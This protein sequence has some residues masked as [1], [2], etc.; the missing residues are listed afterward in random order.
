MSNMN[1]SQQEDFEIRDV[2]VPSD[3]ERRS[4]SSLLNSLTR[5]GSLMIGSARSALG[6]TSA[7][8]ID[9]DKNVILISG[10]SNEFLRLAD[11]NGDGKVTIEEIEELV[12]GSR[13]VF[14]IISYI[15]IINSLN[16]EIFVD[17][18]KDERDNKFLKKFLWLMIALLTATILVIAGVTTAVVLLSKDTKTSADDN[19]IRVS[20]SGLIAA[21]EKPRTYTLLTELPLLPATALDSLNVVSFTRTDGVYQRMT[22]SG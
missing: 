22:V 6:I 19:A 4:A 17:R 11:K 13:L 15:S 2:Y 20:S 21:T 18:I 1:T 8:K 14:L 7:S 10:S 5:S 3:E 16:M 9:S 12:K